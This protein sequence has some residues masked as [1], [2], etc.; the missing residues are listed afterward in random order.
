[1]PARNK[2]PGTPSAKGPVAVAASL[3]DRALR[4]R[5]ATDLRGAIG[6]SELTLHYQP[7]IRL[8]DGLRNGAEALLRWHHPARGSVPPT[9]FIPIA[10]GSDLIVELGG[11]VL[12]RAAE[13]AARHPQLGRVSVNVSVRQLAA[14]VLPVQVDLA[15]AESGLAPERLELELTESLP[16]ADVTQVAAMLGALRSRGIGLALDDFGTGY[17][18][19]AWLAAAAIQHPEAGPQPDRA[20]ARPAGRPG[21]PAGHPRHRQ[22]HA[23]PPGG[24]GVE[25][26]AQQALLA[27]LGFEEAQGFLFGGPM[28]LGMLLA[29]PAAGPATGLPAAGEATASPATG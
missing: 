29:G 20:P 3:L 2:A 18:S 13:E 15:L 7:R 4:R 1:M 6:R 12:R 28:P 16:L 10:E 19:F 25:T 11:W 21:D 24:R 26:L 17:A 22:G 8:A 27:G 14:G 23:A 9:A 5:L